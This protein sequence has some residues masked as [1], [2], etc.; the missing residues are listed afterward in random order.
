MWSAP[1]PSPSGGPALLEMLGLLQRT[2]IDRRGPED[3]KAWFE[4]A[5]AMRLAYAER[6]RPATSATRPSWTSR[7]WDC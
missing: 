7:S 5:Q 6:P 2:D 1:P 4:M 3:P